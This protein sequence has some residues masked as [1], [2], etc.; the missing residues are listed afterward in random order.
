VDRVGRQVVP[1]RA[2]P[3]CSSYPRAPYISPYGRTLR[4]RSTRVRAG[5]RTDRGDKAARGS[6]LS[7]MPK[8]LVAGIA[9]LVAILL[10]IV[11]LIVTSGGAVVASA[12]FG[13]SGPATIDILVG[14][15]APTYTG[16]FGSDQF[17]GNVV[18]VGAADSAES[19]TSLSGTLGGTAFELTATNAS[20]FSSGGSAVPLI[21]FA[22]SGNYGSFPVRGTLTWDVST[23]NS[24]GLE[25]NV[26]G[27]VGSHTLDAS[28]S[29]T[30][31]GA[32]LVG[33]FHYSVT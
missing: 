20:N 2:S 4:Y 28:G 18:G 6:R 29:L 5:L 1:A 15:R 26:H 13:S 7:R 24:N 33:T 9:A 12:F 32:G 3:L 25:M 30:E 16:A 10:A 14:G 8:T 19:E 22:V 23:T 11:I 31:S 27:T 21:E 17:S